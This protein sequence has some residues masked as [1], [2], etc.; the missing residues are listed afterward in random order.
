MRYNVYQIFLYYTIFKALT[1]V[2]QANMTVIKSQGGRVEM[3][4]VDNKFYY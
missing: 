2:I 4:E 3:E 1:F